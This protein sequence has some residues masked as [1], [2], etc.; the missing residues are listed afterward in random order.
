MII[1]LKLNFVAANQ[2]TSVLDNLG[3]SGFTAPAVTHTFNAD[4]RVS[5]L[6]SSPIFGTGYTYPAETGGLTGQ[7]SDT[8][9]R[10]Q[11]HQSAASNYHVNLNNTGVIHV[12]LDVPAAKG[13][14][15]QRPVGAWR[16]T[17]GY[18][19]TDTLTGVAD[20]GWF[21]SQLQSLMG[22]LH[23]SATTASRSRSTSEGSRCS[24]STISSSE[25]PFRAS[26]C[27]CAATC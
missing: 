18:P 17:H 15:Y 5:A 7:L 13:I 20:V 4:R 9:M 16:N 6:L 8:F 22:S 12:T 19:G 1:A 10:A 3:Y 24:A 23:I 11:F 2:D 14:A 26:I 27:A 21:S 25:R